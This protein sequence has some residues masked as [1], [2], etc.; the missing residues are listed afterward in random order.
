M[1]TKQTEWMTCGAPHRKRRA[2]ITAPT[3]TALDKAFAYYN[4]VTRGV[5]P[6]ADRIKR[7]LHMF[8]EFEARYTHEYESR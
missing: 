3:Q 5:M 2:I 7:G 4:Q 6:T 1:F 8:N